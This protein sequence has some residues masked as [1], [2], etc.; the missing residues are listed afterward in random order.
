M[1]AQQTSYSLELAENSQPGFISNTGPKTV[2]PFRNDNASALPF[3]ILVCRSTDTDD[4]GADMPT[5]SRQVLGVS[6]FNQKHE[7][8]NGCPTKEMLDVIQQGE[9][10]VSVSAAVTPDDPVRITLATGVFCTVAAGAATALVEGAKF[11]SRAGGAGTV[12]LFINNPGAVKLT[13]DA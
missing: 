6:V 5:V 7:S 2:Q 10:R 9:V 8:S 4:R 11:V 1:P 13:A 3:G 12:K